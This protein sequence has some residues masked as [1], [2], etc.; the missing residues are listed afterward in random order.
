MNLSLL[1]LHTPT[2][3]SKCK[4]TQKYKRH[5]WNGEIHD[6]KT[7]RGPEVLEGEGTT[8]LVM[9]KTFS[10]RAGQ[11][12]VCQLGKCW[13]QYDFGLPGQKR[14]YCETPSGFREIIINCG[15][16]RLG[17]CQVEKTTCFN[18]L[19]LKCEIGPKHFLVL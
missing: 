10:P 13:P 3:S 4:V 6:A 12:F 18:L 19:D 16:H 9:L 5:K 1:Y 11:T 14:F 17:L 15:F 8:V 2:S 7:Q